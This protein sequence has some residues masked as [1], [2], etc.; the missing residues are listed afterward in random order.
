MELDLSRGDKAGPKD[1]NRIPQLFH[2]EWGEP[3]KEGMEINYS[4]SSYG[5]LVPGRLTDMKYYG[6]MGM[7]MSVY[8]IK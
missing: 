8:F 4:A 6:N 3:Q 5:Q 2:K 7:T 1:Y